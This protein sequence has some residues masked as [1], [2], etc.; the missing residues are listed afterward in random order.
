MGKGTWK[1]IG[2]QLCSALATSY[3]EEVRNTVPELAVLELN[4]LPFGSMKLEGMHEVVVPLVR[5]YTSWIRLV[6]RTL[7][8]RVNR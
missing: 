4:G 8:I 3:L 1:S 5:Y 6:S 2:M 7:V